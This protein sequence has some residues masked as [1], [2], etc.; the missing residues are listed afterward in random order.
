MAIGEIR[1]I[2]YQ[3]IL[4]AVPSDGE[5]AARQITLNGATDGVSERT[6]DE[7][8]YSILDVVD[9]DGRAKVFKLPLAKVGQAFNEF[10]SENAPNMTFAFTK[11][12]SLFN[13][14]EVLR[15]YLSPDPS[16]RVII[17]VSIS[18]F[19]DDK[20]FASLGNWKESQSN[21]GS[22]EKAHDHVKEW[23]EAVRALPQSAVVL[24]IL[25]RPW[26]DYRALRGVTESLRT[27]RQRGTGVAVE[28]KNWDH[29][30]DKNFHMCM[31]VASIAGG[32]TSLSSEIEP[33][34]VEELLKHGCRGFRGP[35]ASSQ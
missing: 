2:I 29:L 7:S 15:A 18:M 25:H 6:I 10:L 33:A 31:T 9:E 13:F 27:P 5:L 1:N 12:T 34:Q 11:T 35:Q 24:I 32:E 8:K 19:Y 17:R 14:A 28:M 16:L 22:R 20:Q 21:H 26:H 30:P 3:Q 23:M 4:Q